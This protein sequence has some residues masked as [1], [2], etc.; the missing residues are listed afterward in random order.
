[1]IPT[2]EQAL[3][4]DD[5]QA[6]RVPVPEWGEGAEVIVRSMTAE[7][8]DDWEVKCIGAGESRD[9][10][11]F[12]AKLV[13]YVVVDEDGKRVFTDA[14]IPAL[15]KKNSAAIDRIA[16][17]A[18]KLNGMAQQDLEELAKNFGMIRGEDGK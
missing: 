15:G 17:K 14:D 18:M 2:R 3:G 11:N 16:T 5:M 1:M 4:C 8:R 10:R 7:E 13:A 6:G 9:I 12:R